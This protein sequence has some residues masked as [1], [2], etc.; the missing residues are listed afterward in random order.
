MTRGNQR[1]VDRLRAAKRASKTSGMSTVKDREKNLTVICNICKQSFMCTVDRL[2]LNQ[3]V[4]SKHPKF[5][6]EKCF[7]PQE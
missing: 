5:G 3:H 7:P 6:F 2:T 1:E 4:E